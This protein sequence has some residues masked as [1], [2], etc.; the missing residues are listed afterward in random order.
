[1]T[2]VEMATISALVGRTLRCRDDEA[3]IT[4]VRDE[5]RDLCSRFTPYPKG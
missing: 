1:M 3:E 2:E 5:V 4:A